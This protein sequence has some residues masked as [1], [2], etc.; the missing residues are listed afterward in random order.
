MSNGDDD[1]DLML[2]GE[3]SFYIH[4][5]RAFFLDVCLFTEVIGLRHDIVRTNS[6]LELCV[7]H[8]A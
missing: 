6:S 2:Q 8:G 1:G 4:S 3:L 5:Y 7:V